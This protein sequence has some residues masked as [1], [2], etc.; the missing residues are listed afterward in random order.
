MDVLEIEI[1]DKM[2]VQENPTAERRARRIYSTA[3]HTE[4]TSSQVQY[5]QHRTP[6]RR[7]WESQYEHLDLASSCYNKSAHLG[8]AGISISLGLHAEILQ[9]SKLESWVLE[10]QW[11]L[12]SHSPLT[13]V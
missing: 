7:R 6:P 3:Q 1:E 12:S 9:S 2:I 5:V 4:L 13:M 8:S 11:R 10:G